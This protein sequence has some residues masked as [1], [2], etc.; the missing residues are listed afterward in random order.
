[1]DLKSFL[2]WLISPVGAGVLAYL[3]IDNVPRLCALEAKLKRWVAAGIS[4]GIAILGFLAT[5]GLGYQAAPVGGVPWLEAVFA[6]ATGAFSLAT[7]IHG[8]R[9]LT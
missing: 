2:V 4:A 8:V 1:V 6:V 7:I 9:D 5:V 3:L